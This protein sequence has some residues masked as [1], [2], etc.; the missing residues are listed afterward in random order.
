MK[1]S[2]S[3]QPEAKALT[4]DELAKVVQEA[5]RA[6]LDGGSEV[7]AVITMRGTVKTIEVGA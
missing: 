6:G 2:T 4:L 7:R 1:I 5:H 3:K